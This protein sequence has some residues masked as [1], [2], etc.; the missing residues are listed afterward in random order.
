MR[1]SLG[2]RVETALA[3]IRPTLASHGGDVEQLKISFAGDR[4]AL[5]WRRRGCAASMPTFHAG[6]KKAVMEAC[7]EIMEIIQV[8]GGAGGTRETR[9]FVSPFSVGDWL[10]AGTRG[11]I[12]DYGIRMLDAGGVD[13]VLFR[14]GA[15]VTCF[16][17][18]CSHVGLGI[19][20]GTII[21]GVITC[22]HYGFRYDRAT[23]ECLTTPVVRSRSH[24]ERVRD[25]NVTIRHVG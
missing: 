24:D 9:P 6:V 3:A 23:G 7:P 21:E 15:A 12:S 5:T 17:D 16:E 13:V 22:P 2:E 1:A 25:D 20:R 11:D 4:G 10:A 18:A 14:R 8:K 19:S